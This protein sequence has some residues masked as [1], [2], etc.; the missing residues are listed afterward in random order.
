MEESI[1]NL[2]PKEEEAVSKVPLHQS[3]FKEASKELITTSPK[4]K[5]HATMGLLKVEKKAP[6]S[7]VKKHTNDFDK[8]QPG[9]L[10]PPCSMTRINI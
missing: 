3:K 9:T 5:P 10:I 1:Y 4:K 7:F 8:S 6:T 2:I